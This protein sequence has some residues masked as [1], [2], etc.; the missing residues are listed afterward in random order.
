MTLPFLLLEGLILVVIPLMLGRCLFLIARDAKEQKS[1]RAA[2]MDQLHENLRAQ[3][4]QLQLQ[5]Y[6][7]EQTK[8]AR[9]EFAPYLHETSG[10]V[11]PERRELPQWQPGPGR[12][13]HRV[14]P[15]ERRP[16]REWSN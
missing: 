7:V 3:I 6:K 16:V 14:V 1:L 9:E 4:A 12:F 5:T 2:Q 11:M 8:R 10:R 13:P 15:R